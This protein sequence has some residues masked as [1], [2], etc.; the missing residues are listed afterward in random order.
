VSKPVRADEIDPYLSSTAR[1]T[2]RDSST[3]DRADPENTPLAPFAT[4]AGGDAGERAL[5]AIPLGSC[6]SAPGRAGQGSVTFPGFSGL[7]SM[8]SRPESIR[9]TSSRS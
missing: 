5:S 3:A 9:F 8:L 7:A 4:Q 1:L 2:G 6:G